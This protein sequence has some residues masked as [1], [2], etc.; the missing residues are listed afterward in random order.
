MIRNAF[1]VMSLAVTAMLSA[2][3]AGADASRDAEFLQ[4][5]V[6]CSIA[7]IQLG[8]LARQRGM[9][10]EARNLGALLARD[11]EQ[12][13][14]RAR[15]LARSQGIPVPREA[16]PAATR[17]YQALERLP[18]SEF[19]RQFAAQTAADHRRALEA[20]QREAR[21]GDSPAAAMAEDALP[22]LRKLL[23]I[24]ESLE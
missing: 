4:T 23:D 13:L 12:A 6:R 3:A 2:P 7:Q 19:D 20:Y 9:S 10:A 17:R 11:H 22:M 1:I 5:A 18:G 8:Q 24:A 21:S 15:R 16:E 14:R